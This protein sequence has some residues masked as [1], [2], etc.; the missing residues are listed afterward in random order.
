MP[1]A[2]L[3]ARPHAAA[4]LRDVI[5]NPDD[6]APRLIFADWLEDH[7]D[8]ERAEFIRLQIE[9][10][11]LS[12]YSLRSRQIRVREIELSRRCADQWR[13][14]LK[15]ITSASSFRRGFVEAVTLTSAQ[16]A[17]HF[18]EVRSPS[19]WERM[20]SARSGWPWSSSQ[21]AK[22]RRGASSSGCSMTSAMKACSWFTVVPRCVVMVPSTF[23]PSPRRSNPQPPDRAGVDNTASLCE[24]GWH[25][26]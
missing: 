7:G 15:Q 14:R 19:I 23:Y 26:P 2:D 16:L 3:Y 12:A 18:D 10:E 17:D 11:K 4:F 8:P 13:G 22:M 24:D 6:D 20:N 21:S 1:P 25:G 5:E 9:G